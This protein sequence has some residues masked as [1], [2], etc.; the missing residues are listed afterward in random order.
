[1]TQKVDA[2]GYVKGSKVWKKLKKIGYKEIYIEFCDL[3]R[4][5]ATMEDNYPEITVK[6]DNSGLGNLADD[7]DI[8]RGL[9][10]H[11]ITYILVLNEKPWSDVF[12][13]HYQCL[14]KSKE[15]GDSKI[16]VK[17]HRKL[18]KKRPELKNSF[19]YSAFTAVFGEDKL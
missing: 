5:Q 19:D 2:S 14:E 1:M 15:I 11:E 10:V 6:I 9:V 3:D 7:Y 18:F 13:A 8:M 4:K 17:Y 16:M 12:T